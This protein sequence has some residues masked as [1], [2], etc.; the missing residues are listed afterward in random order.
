M[1]GRKKREMLR[2]RRKKKP[3]KPAKLRA[4]DETAALLERYPVIGILNMYKMPAA[5]L[6]RIK[7][8][9]GERALIKIIRKNTVARALERLAAKKALA[10]HL[11]EQPGLLLSKIDPFRLYLLISKSRS[12]AAAKPGDIAPTD[13][14]VKAGPTGLM[15]GPAITTLTKVGI[16]ARVEAGK[17]AIAKDKIVL[18]AG[19]KVSADLAAALQLLKLEPLEI[20]LDVIAMWEAGKI[21]T[22]E[23]LAI[24]EERIAA[25]LAIAASQAINLAV[26]AAWPTKQSVALMLVAASANARALGLSAEILDL[27]II[28]QLLAI[29]SAGAGALKSLIK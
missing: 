27:G 28:E 12:P 20:G 7:R 24:D 15:P 17:I 3:P 23:Q 5:A 29:A 13:I 11:G 14:E 1:V 26:A 25:D 2:A 16:P 18:K 4:V 21:Y 22:K 19:E 10:K 6:Q 8:E 9:L